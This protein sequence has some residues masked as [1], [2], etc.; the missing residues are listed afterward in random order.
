MKEKRKMCVRRGEKNTEE[1]KNCKG[2][3]VVAVCFQHEEMN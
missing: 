3:I 1:N 2:M